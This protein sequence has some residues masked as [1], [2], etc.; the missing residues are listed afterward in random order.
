MPSKKAI[1]SGIVA[2]AVFMLMY[3]KVPAI[4]K[5]LGGA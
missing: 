5:I 2:A 1:V 3:N 4:R